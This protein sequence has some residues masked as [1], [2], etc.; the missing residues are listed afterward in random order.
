[1]FHEFRLRALAACPEAFGSTVQEEALLSEAEI[2]ARLVGGPDDFV[3]GAFDDADELVG[4][5][6]LQRPRRLKRQHGAHIW[7]MF[8]EPGSRGKGVASALLRNLIAQAREVDG[9]LQLQLSVITTLPG[10]MRLYES[11]GFR[12]YGIEPRAHVQ[13]GAFLDIE[14]MLLVL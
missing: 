12:S 6:G 14:H 10:A 2:E 5:V 8:V 13:D 1:M 9:L 3:L 4:V 7:G 11:H